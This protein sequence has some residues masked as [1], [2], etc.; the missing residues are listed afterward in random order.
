MTA[1]VWGCSATAVVAGWVP[2]HAS[3][4][5]VPQLAARVVIVGS[6]LAL[7]G[8]GYAFLSDAVDAL[9]PAETGTPVETGMPAVRASTGGTR[10]SRVVRHAL[11]GGGTGGAYALLVTDAGHL[12][13]PVGDYAVGPHLLA[14][15][16]TTV[17]LLTVGRAVVSRGDGHS[18]RGAYRRWIPLAVVHG[19]TLLFV[20]RVVVD[21]V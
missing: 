21:L 4:V 17:A 5:T 1:T 8:I 6:A 19:A 15:G 16:V 3:H 13:L 2:L 7:V 12:S 10:S 18:A 20:G 11:V 14:V 9:P